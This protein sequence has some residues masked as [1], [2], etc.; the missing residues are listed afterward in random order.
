VQCS[1]YKCYM[2]C[3]HLNMYMSLLETIPN[4]GQQVK[5]LLGRIHYRL[6]YNKLQLFL[7]SCVGVKLKSQATGIEVFEDRMLRI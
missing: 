4:K 7:L 3:T 6:T 1:L 5:L 2:K